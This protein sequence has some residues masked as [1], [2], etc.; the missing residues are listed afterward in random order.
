M[1]L[2]PLFACYTK[3]EGCL[4]PEATN[5]DVSAD[6]D[7]G[8]CCIFPVLKLDF[9]HRIDTSRLELN[10]S[11]AND[12]G[13]TFQIHSF[14]FY[15]SDFELEDLNGEVFF[16]K[17]T[18]QLKHFPGTAAEPVL[19]FPRNVLLVSQ[20]Q[21]SGTLGTL[22]GVKIFQKLRF[23]V[24]LNPEINA[25]WPGAAKSGSALYFQADSMYRQEIS[26]YLY[27]KLN[28]Q[29]N[30]ATIDTFQLEWSL[31]LSPHQIEISAN[32]DAK[33][34]YDLTIPL[35]IDYRKWVKGIHFASETKTSLAE[36]I[37]NN[38][39]SSFSIN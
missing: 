8:G 11:F 3:K 6:R 29:S 32:I 20:D 15:L 23:K 25:T 31:P 36:K 24:G 17:D 18:I 22:S 2:L 13:D 30:A 7:C 10:K 4:N 39:P 1:I 5:L 34:G 21:L 26:S 19:I 9:K 14:K 16:I 37:W 33:A 12:V 28:M 27:A 35:T 38:I